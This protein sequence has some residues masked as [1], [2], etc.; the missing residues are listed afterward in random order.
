ML[1]LQ[2]YPEI[3]HFVP[4][5]LSAVVGS[6]IDLRNDPHTLENL[7]KMKQKVVTEADG[8]KLAT[9]INA[10]TYMECSS[11]T[12]VRLIRETMK[13]AYTF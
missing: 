3:K 11:L 6:Q 10:E 1:S 12:S 13:R 8:I 2:W 5:A 7:K 9:R 4:N